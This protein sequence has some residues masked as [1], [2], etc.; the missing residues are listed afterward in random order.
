MI[1]SM[2]G[3]ARESVELDWGSFCWEVRSVNHRYVDVNYKAHEQLR[4]LEPKVRNLVKAYCSR[5]KL[6]VQLQCQWRN[7]QRDLSVNMALVESLLQA[8]KQLVKQTGVESTLG[9]K[10]LLE[11]PQVVQ[12]AD[13]INLEAC[14]EVILDGLESA[15][16]QLVDVREREGKKLAETVALRLD[17][18][19]ALVVSIKPRLQQVQ[20]EL[21]DK[22]LV[23]FDSLKQTVDPDRLE[24]ELLMLLQRMDI[25]EELDRLQVHSIE[26]RNII[27]NGGVVG[28]RLDFL[29]QELHREANT[30]SSKSADITVTQSAVDLKVLIEQMREQIQ[31]IE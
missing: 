30:L 11:W 23:R 12:Q 26:V 4:M 14:H 18:V 1:R 22:L 8:E 10:Q 19:D 28:R 13:V 27:V 15:L 17:D 29:M 2:T 25:A 24:Q 20:R 6:D 21:R 5:G 7:D 3:F 9:S 16:K 31:N